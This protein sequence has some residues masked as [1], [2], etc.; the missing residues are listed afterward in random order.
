MI[1]LSEEYNKAKG[2]AIKEADSKYKVEAEL[3]E[4]EWS[5]N[6]QG[7]ELKIESLTAVIERQVEQIA[8]ITSQ[9]QE[10]NT[11]AQNL[12]MQAFQ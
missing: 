12:A 9:L 3:Q 8:E 6:Q 5:A 7:Y 10:A 2:N 11:Q 4:K 1:I